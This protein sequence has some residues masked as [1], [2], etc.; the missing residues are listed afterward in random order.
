MSSDRPRQGPDIG[1]YSSQ[2]LG[3]EMRI[4]VLLETAVL[5]ASRTGANLW[6]IHANLLRAFNHGGGISRAHFSP[7]NSKVVTAGGDGTV[8]VWDAQI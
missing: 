8:A 1:S 7:D 5:I 2:K 3:C 6:D 4:S